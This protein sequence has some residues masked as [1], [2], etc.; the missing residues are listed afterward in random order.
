MADKENIDP[1]VFV[2]YIDTEKK[3]SFK[4]IENLA[5]RVSSTQAKSAEP[6]VG[7]RLQ[8]KESISVKMLR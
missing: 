2:K 3:Y 1:N 7:V 5:L 8:V 4:I 6:V